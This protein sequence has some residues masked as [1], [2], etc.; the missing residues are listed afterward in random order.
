MPPIIVKTTSSEI[1]DSEMM[2][3]ERRWRSLGSPTAEVALGV[4]ARI[5]RGVR[6]GAGM[7]WGRG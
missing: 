7:L 1:E 6:K 2:R 5:E 3:V 4:R